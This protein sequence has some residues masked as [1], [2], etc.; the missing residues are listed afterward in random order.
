MGAERFYL[1]VAERDA[2]LLY[3][4]LEILQ[5]GP[6][7]TPSLHEV[8]LADAVLVLGE[9]V[10]N[11]APMLALG[12]RQAV[13]RQPQ[14]ALGKLHIPAWDDN[15]VREAMQQQR[16]P[17]FVATVAATRLDDIATQCWRAAPAD[18]A[19][20]GFAVAHALD[21]DAPAVAELSDAM[22][23]LA[24]SIAAALKTA[25]RPLVISGAG[26]G[27]ASVIEAAA[28]VVQ[29]L[30]NIGR[31]AELCFALP[32]CNSLG[33]ALIG[34][35]SLDAAFDA[36]KRG[37]PDTIVILEND[38][39][40]RADASAVDSF[41]AAARHVVVIDHIAHATGEKADVVLPAATFA[42]GDGTLVNNEGRAQRYFQ[43]YVPAGDIQDSW[44]WAEDI[45][46]ALGRHQEGSGPSSFDRVSGA[47][48]ASI[49]AL[50]AIVDA[51][52]PADFRIDQQKVPRESHRYSGRTAMHANLSVFEPEPPRDV[53]S[54]LAFSME[55]YPGQ[56]PPALIPRFWA[57]GWNSVQSVNK[58]QQEVGGPLRGG[59]PGVRLIEPGADDKAASRGTAPPAFE[60]RAGEWLFVPLHHVF[61]SEE[62]SALAPGIAELS[63]QPY[64]ALGPEDAAELGLGAG[65]AAQVQ[66]GGACHE[67][68]VQ[69]KPELQR[70][71]AGL[72]AGLAGLAGLALPASG[73]LTKA[74][75]R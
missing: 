65:D 5:Q 4:L 51:A 43:V 23:T 57:P 36:V 1:G 74:L 58:F 12:L 3:R 2:R 70:G 48:A 6:A 41:L 50:A 53:D 13:R 29:A 72:P 47:C 64:V 35:A 34:G 25:E 22:R 20:L 54:A 33:A 45:S 38:L 37:A 11:T 56:P 21:A 28:S 26:S 60:R 63:P 32:E 44:R 46:A 40:R 67:L 31:S 18:V 15:A 16:G 27:D 62:L 69:I 55:G 39:Y 14:K 75:T 10:A 49:P 7:R 17:L 24:G 19:R 59:D 68:P 71:V 52:P 73:S 9:D 8:G 42:E 66:V 61:G 30:C